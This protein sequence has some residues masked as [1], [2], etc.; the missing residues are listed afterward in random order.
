MRARKRGEAERRREGGGKVTSAPARAVRKR[1][2]KAQPAVTN[3]GPGPPGEGFLQPVWAD[4][5]W[6]VGKDEDT[7]REYVLASGLQEPVEVESG[8]ARGVGSG[9]DLVEN[10]CLGYWIADDDV[11]WMDLFERLHGRL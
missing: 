11:D 5:L 9:P 7:M 10:R 1:R 3:E 4:K 2:R 6:P 8:D